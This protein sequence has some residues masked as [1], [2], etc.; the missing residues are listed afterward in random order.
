MP[1]APATPPSW[2]SPSA[3]R[4]PAAVNPQQILATVTQHFAQ[5]R[6]W[7]AEVDSGKTPREVVDGA[8]GRVH[9][10]RKAAMEQQLRLWTDEA[11]AAASERFYQALSEARK[12]YDL[13]ETVLRRALLAVCLQADRALGP[14]AAL[15]LAELAADIVEL[16]EGLVADLEPAPDLLVLDRR[17]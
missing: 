15:W 12:T 13:Q 1:S 8:R 14:Q 11:L 16:L 9:F 5:L 4:L 17:P 7:R 2:S 10:S 3:A 6:R